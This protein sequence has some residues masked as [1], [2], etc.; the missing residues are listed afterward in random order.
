MGDPSVFEEVS[1]GFYI[2]QASEKALNASLLR[3]QG[4]IIE[5]FRPLNRFTLLAVLHRYDEEPDQE[6]RDHAAW[7]QP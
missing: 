7:N 6:Q 2:Q 3:D 4:A 5:P 1:W